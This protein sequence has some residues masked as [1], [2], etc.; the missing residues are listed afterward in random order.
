MVPPFAVT[1]AVLYF[2]A[3]KVRSTKAATPSKQMVGQVA[4]GFAQMTTIFNYLTVFHTGS[5]DVL[6]P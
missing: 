5:V 6:A 4:S 3:V 2:P 1:S